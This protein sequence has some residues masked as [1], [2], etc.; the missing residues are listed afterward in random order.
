MLLAADCASANTCAVKEAS[1]ASVCEHRCRL[2]LE[3][4]LLLLLLLLM[5]ESIASAEALLL[6]AVQALRCCCK[7]SST[8]R[9]GCTACCCASPSPHHLPQHDLVSVAILYSCCKALLCC[10]AACSQC[11]GNTVPKL[12]YSAITAGS[13]LRTCSMPSASCVSRVHALLAAAVSCAASF[14][15]LYSALNG[16]AI[17]IRQRGAAA[18]GLAPLLIPYVGAVCLSSYMPC[19]RSQNK[20]D[21]TS[22]A[23]NT[24][25]ILHTIVNTSSS[26][27]Q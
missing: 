22:S 21:P 7:W 26:R 17:S 1:A 13:A 11:R 14:G 9:T 25:Q 23:K 24:F 16:S 27:Q 4:L 15:A 20:R 6:C 2:R 3:V 19:V 18:T 10:N 8:A 12:S 5:S